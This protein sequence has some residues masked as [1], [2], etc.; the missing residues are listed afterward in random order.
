[1]GQHLYKGRI[2]RRKQAEHKHLSHSDS[3]LH[4]QGDWL[5]HTPVALASF[6]VANIH[7]L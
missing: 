2:T 6:L 7:E 5:P 1:M 4:M 3:S